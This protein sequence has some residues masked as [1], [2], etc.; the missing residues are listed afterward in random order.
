MGKGWRR[1]AARDIIRWAPTE[2]RGL[3]AVELTLRNDKRALL[4]YDSSLRGSRA[5]AEMFGWLDDHSAAP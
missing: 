3:P 5:E 2:W 1:I 4:C